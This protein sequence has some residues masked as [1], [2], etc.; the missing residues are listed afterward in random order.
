MIYSIEELVEETPRGIRVLFHDG[1]KVAE[2]RGGNAAVIAL[3]FENLRR[4]DE[5]LADEYMGGVIA[6]IVHMTMLSHGLA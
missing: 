1:Q 6:G 3:S 2:L 5:R 4:Q